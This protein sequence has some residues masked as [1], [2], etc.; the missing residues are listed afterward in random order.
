MNIKKYPKFVVQLK[1]LS[2]LLVVIVPILVSMFSAYFVM[3][4]GDGVKY[5]TMLVARC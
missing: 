3:L 2:T 5:V 4:H 1:N